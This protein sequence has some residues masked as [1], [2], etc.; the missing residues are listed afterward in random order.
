[1]QE[2]CNLKDFF[3]FYQ[4]INQATCVDFLRYILT[5]KVKMDIIDFLQFI[6]KEYGIRFSKEKVTWII[7]DT[8]MYYDST[9]EK[10]YKSKE[11]F[12]EEI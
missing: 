11:Y 4:K 12:Y 6:E 7:K 8:E 5:D 1:M 3:L 2:Q 9:M 10:I